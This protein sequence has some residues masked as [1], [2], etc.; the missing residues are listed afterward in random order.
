ME[1]DSDFRNFVKLPKHS[2]SYYSYMCKTMLVHGTETLWNL[3]G[4]G[5]DLLLEENDGFCFGEVGF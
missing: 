5:T 3:N 1:S 4:S 2:Y